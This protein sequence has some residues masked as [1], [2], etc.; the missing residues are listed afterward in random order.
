M[1]KKNVID[2]INLSANMYLIAK[3]EFLREK[4]LLLLAKIKTH[5]NNAISDGDAD[6]TTSSKKKL[7]ERLKEMGEDAGEII[8]DIIRNLYEKIHVVHDEKLKKLEEDIA[9]LK[10]E[11]AL[12]EAKIV[13]MER[14]HRKQ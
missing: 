10:R 14:N 13:A 12:A 3:D 8:N 11:L 6:G 5:Y 7:Q 4:F 1:S 9:E 2:W